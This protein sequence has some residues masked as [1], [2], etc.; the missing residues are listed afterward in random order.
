MGGG[1]SSAI[2]RALGAGD[3]ARAE[4]L[5]L[6]ATVI[7]A[8]AGSAFSAPVRRLC[9]VASF[10]ARRPRPRA[11]AR[12]HLLERGAGGR[13]ADLA[14]Q[15]AGFHRARHRQ[16]A[17]AVADAAAEPRRCRSGSAARSGS[18]SDRS[19]ASAS[20]AWPLGLV[21][22][23][24]AGSAVPALVPALRPGARDAE[25]QGR[26]PGAR[27]VLRHP[28]GRRTCRLLAAADRADGAGA[29]GAGRPLRQSRRWPATASARAWSSCWCRSSSPVGVASVPMVGMAIGARDVARARRVAW[30]A[31]GLAT[32]ALGGIG[33]DGRHCSRI[34]GPRASRRIPACAPPPTSTCGWPGRRSPSSGAGMALYFASQGLRQGAGPRAGCH[35]RGWR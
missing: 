27:D 13:G 21:I 25:V 19:R 34:S 2:S 32:V 10:G 20:P 6:H 15:H 4:A 17:R 23:F 1:V 22:G 12:P 16:H 18:A 3:E 5:A 9:T 35:R 28:E 8:V 26:S 24:A 29:D 11:R 7:G 33:L 14:A 31:A 30:T